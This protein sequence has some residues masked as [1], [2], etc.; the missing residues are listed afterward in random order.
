M[1]AQVPAEVGELVARSNRLGGD[2][3]NTNYGGGNTSAKGTGP[4]PV[5]GEPVELLWV[6]GSGGVLGGRGITAWGA[7]SAECEANSREIITG[8]QRYLDA[9]GTRQPFGKEVPGY[10]PLPEPARLARAAE[11]AP[12]IRGLASAGRPQVGRYTGAPAVLEFLAGSKQ[13][14]A[15]YGVP[16]EELGAFYARRTL[17]GR[18]VLPEHVAAAVFALTAGELSLTT[19]L[20]IPVDAGVAAAFLR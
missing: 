19:G 15:V 18:E 7:T 6:K 9:N 3:R 14:A 12:I 20:H 10:G 13:R 8:A 2:P 1:V 11:L 16:E 5:T 17:L 4:D